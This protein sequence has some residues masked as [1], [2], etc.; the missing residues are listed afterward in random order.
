MAAG[1]YLTIGILAAVEAR[2][3]TGKGQYV[4]T[5][6]LEAATSLQVYEAVHYFTTG[7]NPPRMGQFHRGMAPYQIFPSSDGY[8]TIGAGQQHFFEPFCRLA[9]APELLLDPRFASVPDRVAN[10]DA[11]VDV[12]SVATLKRATDWWIGELDALNIPCGPVF[13]HEQVFNHPQILHRRM[14]ETVDHPKAGPVKTLGVPVKLS[15]TP[16]SIRHAAPMLG[17]HAAEI[18]AEL[19]AR[20]E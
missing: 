9:G 19:T 7:T 6:L 15:G 12:L 14:V 11:L 3:R 1:L 20:N 5:S 18:R 2:H 8:V 13:N 4:E 17:E 10:N 16:A